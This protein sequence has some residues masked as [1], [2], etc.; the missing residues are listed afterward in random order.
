MNS[1][2]AKIKE[3][4]LFANKYLPDFLQ[5]E[6]TVLEHS[7]LIHSFTSS[8]G[9]YLTYD[10]GSYRALSDLGSIKNIL[11]SS[12]SFIKIIKTK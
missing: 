3:W 11:K 12:F 10:V 5:L 2:I 4:V 1:K 6:K 9:D 8:Y 7:K